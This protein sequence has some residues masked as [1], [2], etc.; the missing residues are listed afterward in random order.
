M[1]VLFISHSS[2]DNEA[3]A[4][5]R[6]WLVEQGH[7]SLFLDFDPQDGIPGGR[8]WEQELYRQLRACRAVIVLCSEH[9]MSSDWCFAE[10]THA[11]SLGKP[12]LPIRIDDCQVRSVLHDLQILD[13]P[14]KGWDDTFARLGRGLKLAG[15]DPA[16]L[17]DWAGDRP[18]YPGLLAFQE[19]DAAIFFGRQN[20]IGDTLDT[21]EKAR[22]FGEG[23][24]VLLLGSSG[25]GK[26]S[27]LRAGVV[28]RMRR[29]K[30]R[31]ALVGPFRPGNEP[32]EALARALAVAFPQK[33]D[34]QEIYRELT[35]S[36]PTEVLLRQAGRLRRSLEDE[37][38]TVLLVLDQVEELLEMPPEHPANRFLETLRKGLAETG[39]ELMAVGTLRSDYL[40][41]FQVHS[42][43]SSDISLFNLP[44]ESLTQVI[45]KPAQLAGIELEE[46]L[47]QALLA[48]TQTADALPLLAFSLRELNDRYGDDGK[49]EL[50]EYRDGLGGLKGSVRKAAEDLLS[51]RT[52]LEEQLP[53]LRRAFLSMARVNTEGQF[54]RR[55]VSW[56]ELP[57]ESHPLLEQFV[58]SRLLVSSSQDGERHLEVA[59]E[60][61]LRAWDRLNDWLVE[62]RAALEVRARLEADA[63]DWDKAG[64][65]PDRLFKEP[66]I[67]EA[68]ELLKDY[69]LSSLEKTYLSQ[70]IELQERAIREELEKAQ[71]LAEAE[72]KS[73]EEARLRAEEQAKAT[74]RAYIAIGVTLF[75]A[76][77]A[78]IS[79]FQARSALAVAEQKEKEAQ[80]ATRQAVAERLSI[81][82]EHAMVDHPQ[83]AVLLSATGIQ[84]VQELGGRV[85]PTVE[86]V[87]RQALSGKSGRGLSP[88]PGK[89]KAVGFLPDGRLLAGSE[90]LLKVWDPGLGLE[91]AEPSS[92]ELPSSVVN[93][94]IGPQGQ[95]LVALED[96]TL[97]L[98]PKAGEA[99]TTQLT[100]P[101]IR[102]E[103]LGISTD[104][105][106]LLA[107]QDQNLFLW[108]GDE[109]S[110]GVIQLEG[111]EGR[112][113]C[114]AFSEDGK[115]LATGGRKGRVILWDLSNSKVRVKNIYEHPEEVSSLCFAQDE[116]S[117]VTGSN[118]KL[119]RIWNLSKK[120]EP[121]ILEGHESDL[122]SLCLASKSRLVTVGNNVILIW[123][124]YQLDAP[125]Q[126]VELSLPWSAKTDPSGRW[127]VV[128]DGTLNAKLIDLNSPD[129]FVLELRGHE[130]TL[131]RVAFRDDGLI[132][133]GSED[134]TVRLWEPERVLGQAGV[135]QRAQ[136]L[137]ALQFNPA[138][139]ALAIV[140]DDGAVAI[141][142]FGK[143]GLGAQ[144]SFFKGHTDT[145]EGCEWSPDGERMVTWSWDKSAIVWSLGGREPTPLATL[146]HRDDV[147]G[148]TF[149]SPDHLMSWSLDDTLKLWDLSQ[150]PPSSELV[151]QMNVQ[152]VAVTSEGDR[153]VA[154][155]RN[156]IKFFQLKG[157]EIT[158][159]SE[160]KGPN[161]TVNDLAL[162]SD[163]K[164]LALC[165]DAGTVRLQRIDKPAGTPDEILLEGHT[166][167]VDDVEFSPDSRWLV[168]GSDDHTARLWD[169][170]NLKKSSI[171]LSGHDEDVDK[172]SIAPNGSFVATA[173]NDGHIRLWDLASEPGSLVGVFTSQDSL[174]Q[175]L[176]FSPDSEWLARGGSDA[177]LRMWALDLSQL[178]TEAI[179]R[180]GRHL[181]PY[182]KTSFG[183]DFEIK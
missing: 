53:H 162:S 116:R 179:P 107:S 106:W 138:G 89:V 146:N 98:Y 175:C 159:E 93:A 36:D 29:D 145:V 44:L 61:L 73:A 123:D 177:E 38:E 48:D 151:T 6:E 105:K 150:T 118:D 90:N 63:L 72:R 183:V 180:A 147:N 80:L 74:Q 21:L 76:V 24:M 110:Q 178:L 141:H 126:K 71:K 33:A 35:E 114:S 134:G 102:A 166:D 128:L 140:S 104:G 95:S 4:H 77:F 158:P 57:K 156:K 152:R 83:R 103:Q 9:S 56:G 42:I 15:I 11:R 31:W 149:L 137:E 45:E 2:K 84:H 14:S 70:S 131:E 155:G 5:L 86:G 97:W 69:Q 161:D 173:S 122:V 174:I 40:G 10:I 3:S 51:L 157:T 119:V 19:E 47:T 7:T 112:I 22:R 28:P 135:V 78:L 109:L 171:L 153:M 99:P 26:S 82:A 81:Q 168:T 16:D 18:P 41:A 132:A 60:A 101:S 27:L 52:D 49:L 1:S 75:L 23:R 88:H 165:V 143:E 117:L 167:F 64:K 32:F 176:T 58:Q 163:G 87:L 169:T 79:F 66:Y 91:Q 129:P 113:T 50:K 92:I 115:L 13:V 46:G 125:P 20:E 111:H 136:P 65:T 181:T 164:W 96:G 170:K 100:G 55:P 12:L 182:E 43:P 85:S 67:T 34:A 59:H 139:D 108:S 30:K 120:G 142:E 121:H 172:V 130:G 25:S 94:K 148:A 68:R 17:L 37:P 133:T 124:L 39:S 127:L 54:A 160:L 154:A 62:E 8:N 144:I